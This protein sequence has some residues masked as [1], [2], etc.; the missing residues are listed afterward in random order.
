MSNEIET[1]KK[2]DDMLDKI[3]TRNMEAVALW[4]KRLGVHQ[5]VAAEAIA[6]AFA[7]REFLGY[8]D[9]GIECGLYEADSE[10]VEAAE[11]L[12]EEIENQMQFV[13]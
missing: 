11:R 3:A 8:V 1:K 7:V 9:M 4:D 2:T 10:Y 13:R 5:S 12:R 6:V